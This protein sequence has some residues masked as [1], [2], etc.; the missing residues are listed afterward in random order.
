MPS[1]ID[2][3]VVNG[4]AIQ[5][6]IRFAS[7]FSASE[8]LHSML[9][10]DVTPFGFCCKIDNGSMVTIMERNTTVPATNSLVLPFALD[11][12]QDRTVRIYVFE[13]TGPLDIDNKVLSDE[14][15]LDIPPPMTNGLIEV[16][17]D[18]NPC[19]QLT[20]HAVERSTGTENRITFG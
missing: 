13:V 7:I 19:R 5:A 14:L 2:E 1:D 10:L 6:A 11:N 12:N 3:G 8:R 4:A 15:S 9:L 17:F 16:T 18:A 20:V